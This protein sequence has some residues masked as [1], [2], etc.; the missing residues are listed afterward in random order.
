MGSDGRCQEDV[1]DCSLPRERESTYRTVKSKP[2]APQRW[3]H[4]LRIGTQ[5][6]PTAGFPAQPPEPNTP[7]PDFQGSGPNVE[8]QTHP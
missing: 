1:P 3:T 4:R 6:A 8:T 7:L 2:A 5:A